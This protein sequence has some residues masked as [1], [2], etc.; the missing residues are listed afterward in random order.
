MQKFLGQGSNLCHSSDPSH[1]SDNAR[2]LTHCATEEFWKKFLI[3][4]H[5]GFVNKIQWSDTCIDL[6]P[7]CLQDHFVVQVS[8]SEALSFVLQAS[9]Q[10]P[11]NRD[12]SFLTQSRRQVN[13][14]FLL[15]S[16]L[17]YRLIIEKNQKANNRNTNIMKW[18][19][20]STWQF[21]LWL[22]RSCLY[23]AERASLPVSTVL[24]PVPFLLGLQAIKAPSCRVSFLVDIARRQ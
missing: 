7:M 16:N 24:C 22:R 11:L 12:H 21:S 13:A 9:S 6:S 19:L 3:K 23:F 20:W 5:F 14:L 4:G 2:S 1:Y 15:Y 8:S 18:H 17:L 10:S